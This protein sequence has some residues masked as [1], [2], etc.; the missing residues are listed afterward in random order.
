MLGFG[1][2]DQKMEERLSAMARMTYAQANAPV[3]LS[4]SLRPEWSGSPPSMSVVARATRT[5]VA[6]RVMAWPGTGESR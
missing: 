4:A 2:I 6:W 1:D 5:T 3:A